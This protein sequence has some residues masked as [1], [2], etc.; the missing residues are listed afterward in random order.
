MFESIKRKIKFAK[1]WII[2]ITSLFILMI[3]SNIFLLMKV[4]YLEK[5]DQKLEEGLNWLRYILHFNE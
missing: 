2:I 1:I 5:Q 4:S 3:I